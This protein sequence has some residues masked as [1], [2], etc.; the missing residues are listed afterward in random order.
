VFAVLMVRSGRG[1]GD[2][3]VDGQGGKGVVDLKQRQ[4]PLSPFIYIHISM[5][6]YPPQKHTN[7]H[8]HRQRQR[9]HPRLGEEIDAVARSVDDHVVMGGGGG[10]GGGCCC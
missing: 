4:A 2:G 9:T 3:W 1:W 10:G 7:T 8:K 5:H 6:I